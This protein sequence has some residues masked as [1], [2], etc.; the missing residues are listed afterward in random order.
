VGELRNVP[1]KR[2]NKRSFTEPL[3]LWGQV[4]ISP[5]NY[6]GRVADHRRRQ[7]DETAGNGMSGSRRRGG[8]K[9]LEGEKGEK[10]IH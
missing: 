8:K 1:G 3:V 9:R 7:G 4:A 2:E 5:E 6:R 10:L